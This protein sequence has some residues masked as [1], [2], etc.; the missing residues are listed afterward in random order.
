MLERL[1]IQ[2]SSSF[3][4]ICYVCISK[5][6]AN[7]LP[8][9]AFIWL[10][11]LKY[12]SIFVLEGQEKIKK[13]NIWLGFLSTNYWSSLDHD[14]MASILRQGHFNFGGKYEFRS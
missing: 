12:V 13:Y 5:F 8:F 3:V 14:L 1:G 11:I 9:L 6:K 4:K 7:F 2:T 10:F